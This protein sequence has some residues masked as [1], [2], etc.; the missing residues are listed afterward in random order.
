MLPKYSYTGPTILAAEVIFLFD[1]LRKQVII[2]EV[3]AMPN[4][5]GTI[6]QSLMASKFA[7]L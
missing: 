6:S 5:N 4:K 3:T 7:A 2:I 1:K